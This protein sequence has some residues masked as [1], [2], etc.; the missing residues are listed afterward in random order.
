[1]SMK[2]KKLLGNQSHWSINKELAREIGLNET[3]ILQH[4][5]DWC[6]YH[7]KNTIFQTYEQ[8]QSDLGLSEHAV[9]RVGIP[10]LKELGFISTERKG[11]G[12]KTHYTLNEDVIVQFLTR[13]S[14]E[15]NSTYLSGRVSSTP[16]SEVNSPSL[17]GESTLSSEVKTTCLKGEST[18]P[19][20]NN[21]SIN[22]IDEEDITK[23][24]TAEGAGAG[25]IKNIIEKSIIDVLLDFN[26]NTKD[27]N[28]AVEEFKAQGGIDGISA[29]MQWDDSVRKNY[30]QKIKNVNTI[31]TNE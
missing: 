18:L 15:V 22:H 17:I 27:Y 28:N 31:R 20:S 6:D 25:N 5:I 14:R 10:K 26:A 7:N 19:I 4:L 13:P 9:K 12:Y 21:I 29:I 16:I 2:L 30:Y 23:K 1:M 8:I 24:S 11:V 3:L